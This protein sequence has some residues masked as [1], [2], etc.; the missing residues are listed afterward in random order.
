M[1]IRHG[2]VDDRP[3]AKRMRFRSRVIGLAAVAVLALGVTTVIASVEFSTGP[4]P[5][6]TN[7][8]GIGSV[9]EE[10]ACFVCHYNTFDYINTPG[11]ALEILDLPTTYQAG[12]TYDLRVRIHTDSTLASPGRKWGFEMTAIRASD[13]SGAGTFIP[14]DTLQVI[15][16]TGLY[17]SRTYIEHRSIATR[18]GLAGPIEWHFSWQAPA[19]PAGKIYFYA[20]GNAANGNMDPSGDFIFTTSDSAVDITTGVIPTTWGALK[21][22]Y[23]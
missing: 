19:A 18:T 22:R 17:T 14:G 10:H 1:L 6:M 16:G 4:L 13:G 15:P 7:A 9:P 21:T 20:A 23:R 2:F 8:P 12:M 11:G 5:A 3:H